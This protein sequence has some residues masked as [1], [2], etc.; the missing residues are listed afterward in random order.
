MPGRSNKSNRA[1]P[2]VLLALIVLLLVVA[3]ASCLFGSVDL[4]WDKVWQSLVLDETPQADD[5]IVYV[6]WQMRLPRTIV[7]ILVGAILAVCGAVYQS[8]FRNPLTDP[9]VLGV[10]SGAS[11]GAAVAILM[12]FEAWKWGVSGM[13]LFTALLTVLLIYKIASIGITT[14]L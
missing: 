14:S 3:V 4:P 13:A 1:N 9:Y 2:W 8:I 6:F 10:S 12:G 7:C 11:L 5:G